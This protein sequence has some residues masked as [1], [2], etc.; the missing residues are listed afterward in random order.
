MT[1][2]AP[3]QRLHS[4]DTNFW[5]YRVGVMFET[6]FDPESPFSINVQSTQLGRMI[7]SEMRTSTFHFAR[8][9][10]KMRSDML[11]HV[12]IRLDA[13]PQGHRLN[14][15]DFGQT[16]EDFEE[17][18]PRNVSLIMPREVMSE[19]VRDPGRLHGVLVPD[20]GVQLLSG[21]LDM[22]PTYAPTL[23]L[24]QSTGVAT[25]LTDLIAATLC[26]AP[27][28]R[29]VGREAIAIATRQRAQD[30]I[31]RTITDP[32]LGPAKI[33]HHCGVSRSTLYRLFEPLGG[34]SHYVQ[35]TRLHHT[36]RL[37]C[38]REERRRIGDI[39][40]EAGFS[41]DAHFSRAFRRKFGMSPRDV[42]AAVHEQ[43]DLPPAYRIDKRS[44]PFGAWLHAL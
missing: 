39:A 37:L 42:R 10:R 22:L 11:D 7:I 27:S 16:L 24:D 6:E 30:Y 12:M 21:F 20:A 5:S 25:T 18:S 8:S 31:R 36:Y 1:N 17:I 3:T 43:D 44:Q 38:N 29:D 14:V 35:E 23:R 40:D 26:E 28:S 41:S 4:K 9:A 19:A 32:A 15:V 33:A 34:V 2:L 13:T